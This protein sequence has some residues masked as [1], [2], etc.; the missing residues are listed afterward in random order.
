MLSL[1]LFN[2]S[3]GVGIRRCVPSGVEFGKPAAKRQAEAH[4][5]DES[6]EEKGK[7]HVHTP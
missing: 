5:T 7:E 2:H 6:S 1:E 3:V 4:A